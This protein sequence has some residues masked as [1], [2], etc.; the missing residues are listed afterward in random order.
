MSTG[1]VTYTI[2]DK[3]FDCG[4]VKELID[5]TTSSI[6]YVDDL[7]LSG[8]TPITTGT[9]FVGNFNF[10]AGT[11]GLTAVT[12]VRELQGSSTITINGIVSQLVDCSAYSPS[13]SPTPTSTITPTVTPT[14]T[15]TPTSSL[16]VNILYV[17]SACTGSNR[18][19]VQTQPVSGVT[20]T[21]KTINYSGTCWSYVGAFTAP[22]SSPPGYIR[23]DYTGNYFGTP[24]TVY[25]SCAACVGT[26]IPLPSYRAWNVVWSFGVEC[27]P[28]GLTGGGSGITLYTP[29]SATTLNDGVIMYTN[30]YLTT[31]FASGR[32]FQRSGKIYYNDGYD[33][34][35]FI[36]NVGGGC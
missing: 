9:T 18:V 32:Y 15:P 31:A 7:L 6:Y 16:P 34:I 33:G 5:C 4:T 22:Y 21:G 1:T 10:S 24:S 13:P 3:Y 25:N 26:P 14:V 28:C 27:D 30:V 8:N 11:S 36:C 2:C 17:F 12:Y 19:V 35:S 29:Y 20:T 23:T